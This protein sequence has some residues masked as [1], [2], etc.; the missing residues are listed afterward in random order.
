MKHQSKEWFVEQYNRNREQEDWV[1]HYEE[2]VRLMN[3]LS[4]RDGG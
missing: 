1:Y 2:I 3:A 4:K